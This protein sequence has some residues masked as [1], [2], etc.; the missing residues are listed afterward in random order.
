MS[1]YEGAAARLEEAV[2]NME[3]DEVRELYKKIGFV[4][5]SA[6]ALGLACRFRGVEM[7]KVLLDCGA[8]F[9]IRQTEEFEEKY[10]V[11]SGLKYE[12][13]RS[14]FA[15]YL[16]NVTKKIPGCCSCKKGLKF[17]KQV[18]RDDN[19]K[20][21][22]I[23]DSERAEVVKFL[24]AN[25]EKLSFRPS[26]LLLFAIYTRDDFIYEELKKLG[27]KISQMRIWRPCREVCRR[28]P[29]ILCRLFYISLN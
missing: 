10:G 5:F 17:Q 24:C 2:I 22:Q 1:D 20:L 6:K 26:E 15:L 8:T 13:Y 28:I 3:P 9:D 21:K 25:A 14:D 16:L 19:K 4:E 12:N 11:Y 27:I 23:S 18:T 29:I 7:L